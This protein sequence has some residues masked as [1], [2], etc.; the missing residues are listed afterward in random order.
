MTCLQSAA[1][2]AVSYDEPRHALSATFRDS[3]RTYIYEDVPQEL[4]DA[5]LF[6]D[7]AGAYFNAHIRD[8]FAFHEVT[9]GRQEPCSRRPAS[10]S[11]SNPAV[12]SRRR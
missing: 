8:H 3:G 4:F 2:A 9:G 11:S 12:W 1:L 5:L 6:A 7:S 10:L